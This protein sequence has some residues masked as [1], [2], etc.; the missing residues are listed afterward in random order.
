MYIKFVKT[1]GQKK[2]KKRLRQTGYFSA[3]AGLTHLHC[4][5]MM[6]SQRFSEPEFLTKIYS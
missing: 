1:F 6:W 2:T 4:N 3:G 5:T